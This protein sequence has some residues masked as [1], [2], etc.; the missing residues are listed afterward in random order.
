MCIN[1]IDDP[2]KWRLSMSGFS[3]K[4]GWGNE[5]I[6]V[7]KYP[8]PLSPLDGDLFNK[9]MNDAQHI[10]DLHNATLTEATKD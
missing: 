6:M 2:R 7:A 5:K 8:Y 9:W 1:Y 10:C 4:T 3:I